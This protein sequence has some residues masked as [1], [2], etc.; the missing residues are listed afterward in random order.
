MEEAQRHTPGSVGRT[1]VTADHGA[2]IGD[3]EDMVSVLDDVIPLD[4]ASHAEVD[5][6]QVE[7]PMCY[8]ECFALLTDGRKVGLQNPRAFI[9]W[10]CH[11]RNRSFLFHSRGRHYEVVVEAGLRG[12]APGSVRTILQESGSA[13]HSNLARKFIGIDGELVILPKPPAST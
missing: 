13:Q 5:E 6:Y 10:S 11:D 12:R 2:S 9:G 1:P 4:G 7:T 3:R 8:A